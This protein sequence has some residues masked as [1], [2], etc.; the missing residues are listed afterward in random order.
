ML[1]QSNIV[2]YV[3][4]ITLE[5]GRGWNVLIYPR[6]LNDIPAAMPHGPKCRLPSQGAKK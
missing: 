6:I 5:D 1:L 3:V 4:S 2:V